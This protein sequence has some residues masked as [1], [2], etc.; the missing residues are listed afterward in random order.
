MVKI[1]EM[2]ETVTLNE[3]FETEVGP[4]ILMHKFKVTPDEVEEFPK[5][6]TD[7]IKIFKQQP[8]FISAHVSLG[9]QHSLITLFGNL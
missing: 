6:F 9:V 5:V 7:T 2:G 1:I 4:V 8:G 3:E